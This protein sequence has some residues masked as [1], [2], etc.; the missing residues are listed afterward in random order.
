M[1]HFTSFIFISLIF[2]VHSG[3]A[4]ALGTAPVG[5]KALVARQTTF[6][7]KSGDARTVVEI[8]NEVTAGEGVMS[9]SAF[10]IP[11]TDPDVRF[12]LLK[13]Q[14]TTEGQ[15]SIV[16]PVDVL[17]TTTEA[18]Q[19]S[20]PGSRQ[21]VIPFEVIKVGS[22]VEVTYQLE[23]RAE[24][25][26]VFA[27]VA[28]M[29]NMAFAES[30][31]QNFV[32]DIPLK[33]VAQGFGDIFVLN[34]KN[35]GGKYLLS[36][37]P[38]NVGRAASGPAGK[39]AFVVLTTADSWL[40]VNRALTAKAEASI[41]ALV[42]G[43]AIAIGKSPAEQIE[44]V[45]KAVQG[46][47]PVAEECRDCALRA[48]AALRRL[49]FTASIATTFRRPEYFT[50][51]LVLEMA[52]VPSPGYF[53]HEIVYAKDATGKDWW[54]DPTNPLPTAGLLSKDLL[55]GFALVLDGKTTQ[56]L[57][58]PT[59]NAEAAALTM[60][61]V[62]TPKSDNS[63]EIEST[64][65]AN[66]GASNSLAMMERALGPAATKRTLNQFLNADAP[67]TMEYK[68]SRGAAESV[69]KIKGVAVNWIH[70][71]SGG[72]KSIRLSHPIRLRLA[73]LSNPQE[74][75]FGA[76]EVLEVRTLIRGQAVA[77]PIDHECM[78]RSRWIDFD[79]MVVVKGVSTEVT[80]RVV[81]KER[82]ADPTQTKS[83]EF[84]AVFADA[85]IC[86]RQVGLVTEVKTPIAEFKG[87]IVEKMTDAD[88]LALAES[89]HLE[90][91]DYFLKK[92]YRYYSRKL[93]ENGKDLEALAKMA[94]VL[95]EMGK[96]ADDE[97]NPGYLN[98]ALDFVNRGM[99][100]VGGEFNA[101][102][103]GER[104][105]VYFYLGR[106]VEAAKDFT[107]L[108]DKER[109]SFDTA[110]LG[111]KINLKLKNMAE[112][113]RWLAHAIKVATRPPQKKQA[114]QILALL[115]SSQGR[116]SEALLRLSENVSDAT[117]TA[118][119]LHYVAREHCFLKDYVKCID[120]EKKA[121]EKMDVARF[122]VDLIGALMARAKE[123]SA[124]E[125]NEAEELLTEA[126]KLDSNRL[127]PYLELIDLRLARYAST[128]SQA[129]YDK[130]KLY[131]YQAS[132]LKTGSPE[133]ARR[134]N[135]LSVAGQPRVNTKVRAP[136]SAP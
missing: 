101:A 106:T 131:I 2:T 95:F 12:R 41:K 58:L 69:F 77:D 134:A 94:R 6:V 72:P 110:Y 107:L 36:I 109:N 46:S 3:G 88:A 59:A 135:A 55:G 87:P 85:E 64:L 51:K 68:A 40:Q 10:T 34:H 132:A 60:T 67:A 66:A 75:D 29:A 112:A 123:Q 103:L 21:L 98:V 11:L 52:A 30:E 74:W 125:P 70:E 92:R 1:K 130:V 24:I 99:S 53:N 4:F 108:N 57:L 124:A 136:A 25:N 7:S 113:E 15:V 79:R 37:L 119:D 44:L 62:L 86:L 93:Q 89:P 42:A 73:A 9:Q 47:G 84:K 56:P 81:I 50:Q 120:F 114:L 16:K 63:V 127:A 105:V 17:T 35:E 32:S 49:G 121:L 122:K 61:Q 115:Y 133:L 76:P 19:N 54:V 96:L 23:K 100:A 5:Y 128:G 26:G 71:K 104:A 13:A 102:L 38:S 28:Q 90:L 117:A 82:F 8:K 97:Y 118:W 18:V 14:V 27:G 65:V 116:H 33:Y 31:A 91:R 111:Y 83:P 78:G 45:T 20:A 126:L 22:I 129:D 39:K 43:P 48:T 80:D